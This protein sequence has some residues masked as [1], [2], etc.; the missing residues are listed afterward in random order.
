MGGHDG[1]E[2]LNELSIKRCQPMKTHHILDALRCWLASD[3]V[4]FAFINLN[5]I[6]SNYISQKSDLRCEKGTLFQITIEF[7]SLRPE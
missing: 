1:A 3:G 4:H 2:I 5:P 7:L 6:G